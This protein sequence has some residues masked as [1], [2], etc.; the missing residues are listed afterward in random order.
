MLLLATA[1]ASATIIHLNSGG[2]LEGELLDADEAG[3]L[4]RGPV[5]E[6]VLPRADVASIEYPPSLYERYQR[7]QRQ[8]EATADGQVALAAWCKPRGLLVEWHSHLLDALRLDPDCA[9]ARAELGFIR[10]GSAWVDGRGAL[11]HQPG[12]DDDAGHAETPD[13]NTARLEGAVRVQWER[14][15]RDLVR[16]YFATRREEQY[17]A[18]REELARITDPLALGPIFR[19]LTSTRRVEARAA[20]ID[21]LSR[22]QG[23][24]ASDYLVVAALEDADETIRAQA[25]GHLAQRHDDHAVDVLRKALA[26]DDERLIR[27][28]ASALGAVGAKA[29]IPDLIERLTDERKRLVEEPDRGAF[30]YLP[31]RYRQR[32]YFGEGWGTIG[33]GYSGLNLV[34]QGSF[35][36]L[37]DAT[38][39]YYYGARREPTLRRKEVTVYYTEVRDALK[40]LTGKDFGFDKEA[41]STWYQAQQP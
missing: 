26:D 1:S 30:V 9:E 10:V 2:A 7:Q 20:L 39:G 25:I 31:L 28:A 24:E 36:V 11:L 5:G 3:L 14:T 17:A 18:G 40:Q 33:Y 41:W 21:A 27:A 4:L 29:A 34:T 23:E 32:I 19:V 22:F 8:S 6:L 12:D 13:V 16:V 38:I 35:P 15:I 37:P